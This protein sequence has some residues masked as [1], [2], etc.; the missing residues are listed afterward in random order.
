MDGHENTSAWVNRLFP[1]DETDIRWMQVSIS[2]PKSDCV[3]CNLGLDMKGRD[4]YVDILVP[5][6]KD[7]VGPGQAGGHAG[8]VKW[9]WRGPIRRQ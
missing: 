8:I 5:E 3:S 1:S 4:G 9:S 6:Q 2:V 7:P